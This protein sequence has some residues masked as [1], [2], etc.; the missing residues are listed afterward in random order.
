MRRFG[1][2]RQSEG[3]GVTQPS[4]CWNRLALRM[5]G[6]ALYHSRRWPP[7]TGITSSSFNRAP[8]PSCSRTASSHQLAT[9][10]HCR[11]IIGAI[12]PGIGVGDGALDL[13]SSRTT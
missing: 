7:A 3:L 10:R 9:E 12:G 6:A 5:C 4:C 2:R 11:V 1:S 13:P 8:T